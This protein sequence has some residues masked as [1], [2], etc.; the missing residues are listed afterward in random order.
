[1]QNSLGEFVE[2]L[3]ALY[4]FPLINPLKNSMLSLNKK[5]ADHSLPFKVLECF[6]LNSRQGYF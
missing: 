2:C 3:S 5:P 1:M 6:I 4:L